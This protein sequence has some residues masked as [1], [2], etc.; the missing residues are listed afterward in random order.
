[1]YCPD[2]KITVDS[3]SYCPLCGRKMSADRYNIGTL[4]DESCYEDSRTSAKQG[5]RFNFSKPLC[6]VFALI[7]IAFAFMPWFR[8]RFSAASL[9]N[10]SG[11]ELSVISFRTYLIDTYRTIVKLISPIAEID[12]SVRTMAENANEI[13][14]LIQLLCLLRE[15]KLDKAHRD[16]S[17][18]LH[19]IPQLAGDCN[20][21][22]TLYYLCFYEEY[23]AAGCCPRKSRDNSR[24]GS[25]L[26]HIM[27]DSL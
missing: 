16:L 25:L 2:C 1:M 18:L 11:K 3:G 4:V 8:I 24:R 22:C 15:Q 7:L 10:I 6:L 13:M 19:D 14:L 17:G 9:I 21:S 26:Y 20:L 12:D 27:L 5:V 23:L